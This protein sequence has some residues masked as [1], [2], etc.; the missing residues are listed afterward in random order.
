MKDYI[1]LTGKELAD[2]IDKL[3]KNSLELFDNAQTVADKNSYGLGISLLILSMEET[4]KE[5]VLVFDSKDFKFRNVKGMSSLFN[6]HELRYLL[7][8]V[9]SVCFIF[10]EDI[11]K[12]L[13]PTKKNM[14]RLKS[15]FDG[16]EVKKGKLIFYAMI[17]IRQ[18]KKEFKWHSTAGVSREKG[19]YV[20]VKGTISTPQ[21]VNKEEY[22]NV[23][24]R[25]RSVRDTVAYL[26][27]GIQSTDPELTQSIE[28]LREMVEEKDFYS[29]VEQIIQRFNKDRRKFKKEVLSG[30]E[31]IQERIKEE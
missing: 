1:S 18:I 2:T 5:A 29:F 26:K 17:K 15:F 23:L 20:D 4:M 19:F 22:E 31:G 24:K 6:N 13:E 3:N 8:M 7:S 9:M 21:L 11:Q 14:N 27:S 10:G 12:I 16:Q 30:M 25:V 28:E